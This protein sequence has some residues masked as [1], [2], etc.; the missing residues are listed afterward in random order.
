MNSDAQ[1]NIVLCD[2][3]SRTRITHPV[4]SHYDI[5]VRSAYLELSPIFTAQFDFAVSDIYSYEKI[6]RLW[7]DEMG[8]SQYSSPPRP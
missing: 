5:L 2:H 7:Y 4:G 6:L 3:Y 1:H 8:C